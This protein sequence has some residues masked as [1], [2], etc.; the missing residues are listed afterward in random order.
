MDLLTKNVKEWCAQ[1]EPDPYERNPN[2]PYS[3]LLTTMADPIAA[4]IGKYLEI[5]QSWARRQYADVLE[6]WK[7]QEPQFPRLAKL[8]KHILAVPASQA[9]VE[10]V[11][12]FL[13]WETPKERGRMLPDTVTALK[14]MVTLQH[15]DN[16]MNEK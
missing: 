12:S 15:F 14:K 8:A 1:S 13:N 10:R 16:F 11:F 3:Q 2:S 5:S 4:E 7:H 6:F 9:S